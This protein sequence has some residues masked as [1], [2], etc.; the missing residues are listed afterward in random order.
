LEFE[1]DGLTEAEGQKISHC[2]NHV[3]LRKEIMRARN[4]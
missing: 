4:A 1:H 3:H 2:V